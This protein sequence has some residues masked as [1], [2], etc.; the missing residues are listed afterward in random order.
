MKVDK[1]DQEYVNIDKRSCTHCVRLKEKGGVKNGHQKDVIA[2]DELNI[3]IYIYIND[4]YNT[5]KTCA[6]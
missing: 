2:N 5:R 6:P 3:Y 1:D 4:R